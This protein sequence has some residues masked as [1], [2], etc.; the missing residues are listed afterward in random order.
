MAYDFKKKTSAQLEADTQNNYR[1]AIKYYAQKKEKFLQYAAK[2]AEQD[3]LKIEQ[4][5]I[6]SIQQ[7]IIDD[8]QNIY[9][10][11]KSQVTVGGLQTGFK[12][13]INNITDFKKLNIPDF[14][15]EELL[16]GSGTTQNIYKLLGLGYERF[17]AEKMTQGIKMKE[18]ES[19]NQLLK[20][21]TQTG[22]LVGDSALRN[23]GKAIRTDLAIGVEGVHFDNKSGE[24][25][26]SKENANLPVELAVE[27]EIDK[28][29]NR[30]NAKYQENND[31]LKKY[32]DASMYGISVKLWAASPN[33]KVISD[34][35]GLQKKINTIF[36][37]YKYPIS[38]LYAVQ[39]MNKEVSN[40]LFNILGLVNVAFITGK[41]LIWTDEFLENFILTMKLG[42]KNQSI[43]NQKIYPVI[44]DKQV[45][46]RS[47]KMG[48]ALASSK[49][50][51]II[52]SVS[53]DYTAKFKMSRI[54]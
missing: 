41:K 52:S 36:N 27:I 49:Q 15:K 6:K 29:K 43:E 4:Q 14:L 54:K 5:L 45:I 51:A 22:A 26:V 30:K 38:P 40:Y 44:T 37:M 11:I 1:I 34:V 7:G 39:I 21:F 24:F 25:A 46:A 28:M 47:Y 42:A 48:K 31:I 23:R 16:K 50:Y 2:R 17:I 53:Y 18:T 13:S 10:L 3:Q 32:A 9:N 35:S 8:W 33:N 12:Y 20:E 19:I